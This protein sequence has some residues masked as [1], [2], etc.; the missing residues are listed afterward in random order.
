MAEEPTAAD[1]K[2]FAKEEL[3]VIDLSSDPSVQKPVSISASLSGSERTQLV[4]LLKE[5]QDVF[6]WQYN[7]MPG[8]GP[9]LVVHSLNVELG[10]KHVVQPMRTF[11][12]E[13]EAQISQ[14]VKKLLSAGF[15]K[16][17]QHPQ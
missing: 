6:A 13:V 8:I 7:E 16:P 1:P 12:P 9:T 17:I 10:A 5:Y 11:H 2:I 15:I 3:E 14:E 4:A